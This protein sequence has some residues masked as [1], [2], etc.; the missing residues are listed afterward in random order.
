[1][2]GDQIVDGPTP[3]IPERGRHDRA[4]GVELVE[5][6]APV[7]HHHLPRRKADDGA[8]ALADVEERH[9][10]RGAG[11]PPRDADEPREDEEH[12]RPAPDAGARAPDSR[13]RW[14]PS[15]APRRGR[16]TAASRRTRRPPTAGGRAPRR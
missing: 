11:P 12:Q 3:L 4:P 5:A 8:V 15:T 9:L 1:M 7:D 14:R 6:L 16:S 10:Q 13:L 2:A